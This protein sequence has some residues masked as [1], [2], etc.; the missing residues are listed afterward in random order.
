MWNQIF[1]KELNVKYVLQAVGSVRIQGSSEL[2]V[3]QLYPRTDL[4]LM[5]PDEIDLATL[6]ITFAAIVMYRRGDGG[7]LGW[8]MQ[9]ALSHLTLESVPLSSFANCECHGD[10]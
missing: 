1:K 4:A 8:S 3:H 9:T 2:A 10:A 5:A 6:I 7:R